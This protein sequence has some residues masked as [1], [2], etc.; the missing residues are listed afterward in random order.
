MVDGWIKLH[1]KF[2]DWQWY[3]NPAVKSVFLHLLLSANV[4]D[5]QWQG[6]TVKRGQFVSSL[7]KISNATGHSVQEVRTA[8][9]KLKS[10]GC[11]TQSAYPKFSVFT[12]INYN[13]YQ[14]ATRSL[15]SNQQA[16]NKQST[17]NQ[18][19][20]NNNIRIKEEKERKE[21]KELSMYTT[22]DENPS[23]QKNTSV[24]KTKPI[25][26]QFAEFVSMTDEEYSSLVAKVG[27]Q[28][29]KR[30][31]EI[32]DNYKGSSGRK[33]CSD[34]RAILN[35]VVKRYEEERAKGSVQA[36]P[37]PQAS[38]FDPNDPYKDWGNGNV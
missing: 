8:L 32:L 29:A 34:Y 6:I 33:Y 21:E 16:S 10:T 28:G 26:K 3:D 36:M 2:L 38:E 24:K 4:E 37:P 11:I 12:V 30:C 27:E 7:E 22:A 14:N 19:A 15:T 9:K 17:G 5:N 1:R 31:V 23:E 20:S 25:K 13:N 18:Q 35:W